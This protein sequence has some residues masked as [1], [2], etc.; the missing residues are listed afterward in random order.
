MGAAINLPHGLIYRMTNGKY[1]FGFFG[2][3]VFVITG[4]PIAEAP[5]EQ[6]TP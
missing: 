6:S 4:S 5:S 1:T 2:S 3:L